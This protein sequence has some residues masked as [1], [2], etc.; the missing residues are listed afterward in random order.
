[1]S[2]TLDRII[3]PKCVWFSLCL[4]HLEPYQRYKFVHF[5]CSFCINI[6]IQELV[7]VVEE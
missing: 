1:M 3:L 4:L 5:M 7:Y 2:Q 6:V